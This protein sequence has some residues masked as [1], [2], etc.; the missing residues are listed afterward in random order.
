MRWRSRSSLSSFFGLGIWQLQDRIVDDGFICF[1]FAE[2]FAN[3]D[4]VVWNVGGEP[5]DGATNFLHLVLIAALKRMGLELRIANLLL[6]SLCAMGIFALV[7][8]A[9]RKRLGALFP[10]GVAVLAVYLV[11]ERMT[12]TN[13][14]SGLGTLVDSLATVWVWMTAVA[15]LKSPSRRS[16][17]ILA[18]ASFL[19]C[20]ARPS[21]ALFIS[22][23]YSVLLVDAILDWRA[24]NAT[25]IRAWFVASACTAGL[26]G[27]Y[28][29]Y[30]WM[31]FGYLLTN[32]F[33][34]KSSARFDIQWDAAGSYFVYV[35]T[36][37][38][39]PLIAALAFVSRKGLRQLFQEPH[40]RA[41]FAATL[42]PPLIVCSYYVFNTVVS[43]ASFR[44][45]HSSYIFFF[46]G[47]LAL[48]PACTRGSATTRARVL[49]FSALV[50]LGIGVARSQDNELLVF[51]PERAEMRRLEGI[52]KDVGLALGE[53]ELGHRAT[54]LNDSA[55]AIPYFSDFR[56]IDRGGLVNNYLSGR[57]PLT[58]LERE[59]YLWSQELD[60]YIGF[61]PQASANATGPSEDSRMMS[62]YVR[63][64][65][66]NNTR[67]AT[68]L[69]VF[70]QT[71]ELLHLRMREL[72]DN[73]TLLGQL[74][75]V[76]YWKNAWN[77]KVFAYV[78]RD[79]EHAEPI[80]RALEPLIE[81]APSDVS[82]N[83]VS[84]FAR[85]RY[86]KNLIEIHG[87]D[88]EKIAEIVGKDRSMAPVL[89]ARYQHLLKQ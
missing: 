5:T 83:E 30:K 52:L 76:E 25:R 64:C 9:Y 79:S 2:N 41:R 82:L 33:Y 15:Q 22:V 27:A 66:Q 87:G 31:T 72:R 53:T 1:R 32:P 61:E 68:Y 86:F 70:A 59:E 14:V 63:M 49:L 20:T 4:G 81:I 45:F 6:T 19:A 55:G 40:S 23:L 17:L 18:V 35:F 24:G 67:D 73:W 46:V 58:G 38:A 65:L 16:A 29:A 36:P 3:G 77:L 85:Q 7:A 12:M 21:N 71:P 8:S 56:H 34:L 62:A 13:T 42:L 78:R 88:F 54:L 89:R 44:F 43:T 60:L 84:K 11:D 57:E 48:L 74:G 39:I 47:F 51:P 37:L 10:A 69:R 75:S 28:A 80:T 50:A 26:G